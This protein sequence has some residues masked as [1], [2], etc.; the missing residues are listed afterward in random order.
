VA[1]GSISASCYLLPSAAASPD[2]YRHRD[3]SDGMGNVRGRAF[4]ERLVRDAGIEGTGE[5]LPLSPLAIAPA[6]RHRP[7]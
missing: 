2:R 4:W 1:C 6:A 7:D 3:R 5:H